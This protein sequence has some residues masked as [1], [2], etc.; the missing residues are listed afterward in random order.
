M[1]KLNPSVMMNLIKRYMIVILMK[2]KN[3]EAPLSSKNLF[4][5][6]LI[7]DAEGVVP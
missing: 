3:I 6:F 5:P 7:F 4:C 2:V 1:I